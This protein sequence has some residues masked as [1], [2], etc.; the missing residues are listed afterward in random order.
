[1]SM[2][3][4]STILLY[5]LICI[6][7]RTHAQVPTLALLTDPDVIQERLQSLSDSERDELNKQRDR[8]AKMSPDEQER[9]R[10][11]HDAL[12]GDSRA[13][14]LYQVMQKYR[15]WLASLSA[16]QRAKVLDLPV[17]K[18]VAEIKKIV[19]DQDRKWLGE[20]GS[21]LKGQ[22]VRALTNFVQSYAERHRD[23]LIRMVPE[24]MK[25]RIRTIP[26]RSVR[27]MIL[28]S[29]AI[30][31]GNESLP[32]PTPDE[33]TNLSASLSASARKVLD[34]ASTDAEKI[35][36]VQEWLRII[37]MRPDRLDMI[38]KKELEAFFFNDLSEDERDQLKDFAPAEMKRRLKM[39][40]IRQQ[41][42]GGQRY[43]RGRR[44]GRGGGPGEEGRFGPGGG[45]G[46]RFGPPPFDGEGRRPPPGPEG[47]PPPRL[48]DNEN[49]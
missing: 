38:P 36:V 46:G 40:Y 3:R 42:G 17:D 49:R 21:E 2:L 12:A 16:E 4:N 28:W 13:K 32:I 5:L 37:S 31:F 30:R 7:G 19:A 27:S 44:G 29:T 10:A 20:F 39:M 45:D 6:A 15:E 22:D 26:S 33:Y 11:F 34:S 43:G 1:M 41:M 24:R 23:E 8:F 14:R 35:G 18:R 47:F 25:K 48:D 9:F